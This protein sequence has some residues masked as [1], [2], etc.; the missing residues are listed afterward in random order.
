MKVLSAQ[1]MRMADEATITLEKISS[2]DLMERAA[3]KVFDLIHNRLQGSQIPIHVFC[4]IGNNGGD[5]LVISRLLI[6][7][8]YNVRTY[9]VNF[10]DNRSKNFLTNYDRLKEVADE[11]PVQLKSEKDFPSLQPHDMVIDAI[12]GIGLNR[13]LVAWV[14]SLIKH[15]NSTRSFTLSIDVPSGLYADKAPDDPNG[16]IFADTTITFQLPKLVFFLPQTG[17]YSR[18]VEIIDIGLN[19]SFL[20][21]TPGVADLIG[22]NEVLPLYR[23]RHKYSHK[24]TFGHCVLVGGSYGKIG[25]VVLA[26]RAA[27]KIGAGLATAYIPE[28]G[29]N[30][31]QSTVPEAMVIADDDD[32]LS[33]I[34]IDFEPSSV[35]IGIGLGTNSKTIKAFAGFLKGNKAPIVIDADG[36]NILAKHPEFLDHLSTQSILTPHPK[37]LERLV[38]KWKDDFEKIDKVKKFSDQYDCIV[39]IKGAN[40]ITVYKEQL[41]VNNTGNPGMATA[42]S[43]D[44]LTGI[45]TGLL[46]QGYSP[47]HACVFGVYLHGSSGDLASQKNGFEA[48]LA[49]D[50]ISNIGSAYLELFRKPEVPGQ[51]A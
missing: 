36:I 31:L 4:G 17:V 44:V 19:Q 34:K 26:T 16:V 38:G 27:L 30:V 50:I 48:V 12:F 11:W 21:Q 33:E 29:Y 18:D 40:S 32:E 8:G 28:C 2:L 46:S 49:S 10:S 6:E 37:E 35:G 7:H 15:I 23:S 45:I 22:K 47:L 9:I 39:L 3:T 51:N 20:Q 13:P 42:G 1:Q 24:G 14:I 41:Y 5:G 43:G 25:S